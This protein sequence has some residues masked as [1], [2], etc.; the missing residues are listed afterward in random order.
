MKKFSLLVA[1][2][3]LACAVAAMADDLYP[4]PWRGEPGSSWAEW[5]FLTNNQNPLPD[6]GFFPYG[7]PETSVYPGVGQ[8]WWEECNGREGVWP[9]SGEIWIN[10]PNRPFEGG[11]KEIYI[12]L[13]WEPQA[14]NNRPFV[15]TTQ[16]QE[17]N[18]TLVSETSLGGLWMH[19]IYTIYLEP[20]PQWE[21]ILITGGIDVDQLVIDTRCVPEPSSIL[22]LASGVAGLFGFALRRRF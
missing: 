7:T 17:V 22:A 1:A 2:L 15:S 6:N 19:S 12:Q 10:F 11:Y 14:P 16:P 3:L 18:A 13:T 9:L 5:K 8:V 21:Q 20:N 4:P